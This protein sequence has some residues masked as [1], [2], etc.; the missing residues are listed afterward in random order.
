[1][2][3]MVSAGTDG[4]PGNVIHSIVPPPPAQGEQKRRGKPATKEGPMMDR[5]WERLA[6]G[7]EL[8][9][10]RIAGAVLILVVGVVALR[11][12][13]APL[14][15]LLEHGRPQSTASSFLANSARALL[16]VVIII[17]VLQQLGVETT[18][19][20]TV[21]ATAG[22]AVALSLQNTLSNFT[23][24]LLVLSFRMARV[25]DVIDVGGLRGR[26]AELFPF[27]VV[28]ITE[29]N[30]AVTVPNTLLTTG[31]VR[32]LTAL[33][34]RR[35]QWSLP[36]VAGDDLAAAKE[37]LL[38][39]LRAD[40]RVLPVPPPRAFV[41]EWGE[42]R[43]LAVQGWTSTADHAAVQ[44]E[45]LEGLGMALEQSRPRGTPSS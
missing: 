42:R 15:R 18:S 13:V 21:L 11:Y 33:P 16:L 36:L 37:A 10:G 14:R 35:A 12:L 1:M 40:P 28:L 24:G 32:N 43:V 27:H 3:G 2:S 17:G 20:L 34:V 22:L 4:R 7:F 39:R 5:L 41:Q 19:L 8:Y 45:L 44:E 30:Q 25:G 6:Q 9:A 29:D 23:A 26:V 38:R 31:G